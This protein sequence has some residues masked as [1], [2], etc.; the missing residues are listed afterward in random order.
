MSL[1]NKY[2]VRDIKKAALL[3][4]TNDID[5][6]GLGNQV[7]N[8]MY[9]FIS[10]VDVKL[11]YNLLLGITALLRNVRISIVMSILFILVMRELVVIDIKG[12][13]LFPYNRLSGP[14]KIQPHRFFLVSRPGIK[15]DISQQPVLTEVHM[16]NVSTMIFISLN[17]LFYIIVL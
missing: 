9:K 17:Y 7:H 5:I 4:S 11:L 1:L 15:P 2:Y 10:G 13:T 6:L 3:L 16:H 12:T 14:R 8:V